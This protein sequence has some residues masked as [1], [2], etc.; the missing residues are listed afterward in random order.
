MWIP[1]M[2]R[3]KP[4]VM[5]WIVP[6]EERIT[7]LKARVS[8]IEAERDRKA[9]TCPFCDRYPDEEHDDDCPFGVASRQVAALK[10]RVAEL[11]A[12]LAEAQAWIAAYG[13]CERGPYDG[14]LEYG[15][16]CECLYCRCR[17]AQKEGKSG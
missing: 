12:E 4:E 5:K 15:E 11:K 9:S 2:R 10:V 13:R 6:S 1:I 17:R 16:Q 14:D 7:A 3:H 8:E